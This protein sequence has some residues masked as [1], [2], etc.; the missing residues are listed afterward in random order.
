MPSERPTASGGQDLRD[1]IAGAAVEERA[2]L[3][4]GWLAGLLPP[5]GGVALVAVGGLGRRELPP[6]PDVDLLLLHDGWP[7]IGTVADQ[8][9]YPIWE[10]KLPLDHA[11]RTVEEAL[12]VAEQDVKAALGLLDARHL[13]GDPALTA[14]LRG[15]AVGSWQ[16]RAAHRLAALREVTEAR[17]RD[18]GELAFLLEGDLKEARGGLRDATTLRGI[19]YAQIADTPRPAA[20]AA[21][22]RLR[23]TREALHHAAGRRCDRLLAELREPV[24][25]LLGVPDRE[26]L[27][28]RV[29]EDARTLAYAADDA[30]RAVD[31]WRGRA[32]KPGPRRP[33]ADGVVESGGEVRLARALRPDPVLPLRVAAAAATHR[34]PIAVSTLDWLVAH[35]PPLPEPW[36]A[37][38]RNAFLTLLGAGPALVD[39]WEACDRAGLVT[40]WLPE[41]GRVRFA[42]QYDPVH[43]HTVDRHLIETAATAARY[44]HEVTRPDLLVLGALVH[45]LGKGLGECDHCVAGVAPAALVCAR[46][47]L[48][49]ADTAVITDLVRH[50]LLLADV[51]TRRDLADP[52]TL[53]PVA[54]AVGTVD[55]LELLHALTLSDAAAT[56][57]GAWSD[58]KGKLVAELVGRVAGYLG[59]G[60]VPA[61][62][63]PDPA[64]FAGGPLPVVT[65]R[66]G[67]V[68]VLAPDR[69]GLLA[70][71]AGCLARHRLDVLAATVAVSPAQVGLAAGSDAAGRPEPVGARALVECEVRPRYGDPPAPGLL[72]DA[73]RRAVLAGPEPPRPADPAGEVR[74]RWCHDATDAT[75]LEVRAT[76]APG[77]LHR[78]TAALAEAGAD[79]R[80]ARVATYGAAAVDAFY[81]VGE[82]SRVEVEKAVTGRVGG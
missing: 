62:G 47:G 57:P 9:W 37:S 28:R 11:V 66:D 69:P 13:A 65:W 19:G 3:L 71:V 22:A 10:R 24:A 80:T 41:W 40:R 20:R 75:I 51:A 44:A 46:I 16:S 18:R 14:R 6:Y 34:L 52:A 70:A 8:V 35:C 30:W 29:S 79:V 77:L 4:D 21:A 27:L 48:S 60:P 12:A 61:P 15:V 39:V 7:G 55:Q 43:R 74:L 5:G 42:P 73:L 32:G 33:L 26:A 81:L 25:A 36:P 49:A 45:D 54:E 82:Y 59:S 64:R 63:L 78:I 72:L 68:S 67:L 1:L 50:H 17:W 38:A 2:E 31:R 23:E 56:G 53:P 58:W 76:D